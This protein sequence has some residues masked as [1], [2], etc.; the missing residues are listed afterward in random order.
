MEGE[1]YAFLVEW[2]DSLA[3]IVRRYNF[4]FYPK[5]SSVEMIDVKNK[6]IFLKCTKEESIRLDHCYIGSSVNL[7]GR[8][9]KFVEYSDTFTKTKLSM[10]KEKTL[11]IFKPDIMEKMPLLLEILCTEGLQICDVKTVVLSKSAAE[12][13]Y[14]EHCAKP[15]FRTLVSFMTEGPIMALSLLADNAVSR[16]RELIGPTNSADARSQAPDSL[17]ARFGTDQTR[18]ACHGSDS[19]VSAERET[20]FFF[21]AGNSSSRG[22]QVPAEFDN[23][24]LCLVKPYTMT[25]GLLGRVARDIVQAGFDISAMQ[26]YHFDKS[27]AEEFL[28]V[29]RGVVAEYSEMVSELCSGACVA[30]ALTHQHGS[31]CVEQFRQFVGPADPE[32]AR[33]L[34][35]STLRAKYGHNKLKNAVHCTDLADDG[36]LEVEYFFKILQ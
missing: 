10:A 9:L 1:R 5:D 12:E 21:G 4:L 23:C 3:G 7:H 31:A 33:H 6:R 35:P 16:W 28:E 29:Y 2:Y 34:R 32:I 18:N 27:T 22:L 19:V 13:F 20:E 25:Q 17:R 14:R 36:M 24:T 11:A 30:M 26:M 8:Q 15:F